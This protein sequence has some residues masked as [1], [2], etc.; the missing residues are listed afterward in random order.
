MT[1]K[2]VLRIDCNKRTNNPLLYL[3]RLIRNIVMDNARFKHQTLTVF[4]RLE[5]RLCL[6]F[7]P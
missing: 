6:K 5:F 1:N 7:S 2:M 3:D 4:L